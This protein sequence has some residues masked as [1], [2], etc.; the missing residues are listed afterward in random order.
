MNTETA[1]PPI[2]RL[3]TLLDR[4]RVRA[5]LFHTGAVCGMTTFEARPGRAFVHVLRHGTLEVRHRGIRGAARTV[6]LREP[7]VLLYPRPRH[8]VFVGSVDTSPDLTCA[9]LDFDGG[10]RNPI[11][12][13]LPDV[14]IVPMS[15]LTGIQP[16]L[17][18]L[19]AE[20]DRPR[21]GSRV[22]VD[23][24]FETVVILLLR[25]IID[26]PGDAGISHGLLAGL[27]DQRLA[28]ALVAIHRS[29][30]APW[31]IDSMAAIA[32]MSRSAFAETFKTATGTTPAA[33]VTDWR[34]T[35]ATAM[36]RSR[37]PVKT[38]AAELGFASASSLSKV[39]RQRLGRSPRM[40]KDTN[41]NVPMPG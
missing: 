24:L 31:T 35:L 19:F 18:L 1:E 7:S 27:S 28:K 5:S 10:D 6:R 23:R 36:I 4:F 22:L 34:L 20:A 16:A 39:F 2:D 32:G 38:I 11:V 33:Y 14:L 25:W 8:H 17:D 15:A 37:L 30:E 29:P 40:W 3:S 12:D 41:D 26:H 13:A 21:C 9:T